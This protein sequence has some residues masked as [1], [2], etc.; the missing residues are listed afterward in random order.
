LEYLEDFEPFYDW[1]CLDGGNEDLDMDLK[2][3]VKDQIEYKMTD[4]NMPED[5][6]QEIMEMVSTTLGFVDWEELRD[7]LEAEAVE[8]SQDNAFGVDQNLH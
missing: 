6:V 5:S 7:L 1:V 3:Y 2:R 8:Y 4:V